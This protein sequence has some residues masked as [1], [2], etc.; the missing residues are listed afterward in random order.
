[1]SPEAEF[2]DEIQTKVLNVFLLAIHCHL[3]SFEFEI[4]LSSNSRILL[5]ISSNLRNLLHISTVK[6]LYTV[7][8]KGG[9]PERKPYPIPYGS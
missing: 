4:S 2:L 7:K 1:M 9:K 8:E 5:C 6:E 3:Y